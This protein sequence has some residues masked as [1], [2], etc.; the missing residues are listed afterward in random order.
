MENVEM[1][2]VDATLATLQTTEE[3]S[4]DGDQ[5]VASDAATAGGDE[6]KDFLYSRW[7][8][9]T[10]YLYD[11]LLN[12]NFVWPSLAVRWG[13]ETNSA[14]NSLDGDIFTSQMMFYSQRTGAFLE[15]LISLSPP[16]PHQQVFTNHYFEQMEH[17]L[18]HWV[19]GKGFQTCL[20]LRLWTLH[21]HGLRTTAASGDSPRFTDLR[22]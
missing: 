15:I 14:R 10:P 3:N 19:N 4:K 12:N 20:L 16:F 11:L 22:V 2:S 18:L 1:S 13:K 9:H 21:V 7:K 6:D 8:Q 5:A 17:I